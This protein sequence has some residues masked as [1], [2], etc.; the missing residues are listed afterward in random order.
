MFAGTKTE[1]QIVMVK[2]KDLKYTHPLGVSIIC[3]IEGRVTL[4]KPTSSTELVKNSSNGP[5]EI[6]SLFWLDYKFTV[7]H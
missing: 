3:R 5:E 4:L 1:V 7:V 6:N 2:W